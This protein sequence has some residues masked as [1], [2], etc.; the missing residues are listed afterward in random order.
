M[1]ST[2]HEAILSLLESG[3]VPYKVYTHAPC[4]TSEESANARAN[5]GA[6]EAIGAKAILCKM[7]IALTPEFNVL[8]LPGPARLDAVALKML[9]P[10]LKRVRF[11]TAQEMQ[12]LCGL[13][14]GC[15]PPFGPQ[16]FENVTR[17]F[18]DETLREYPMVGF[19]AADFERSIVLRSEDYAR[20][21]SPHAT[22]AKLSIR[23]QLNA[24]GV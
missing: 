23:G 4:R 15:F 2:I 7:Q 5:A 10:G 9:I 14:P 8:V 1:T 19:N 20:I 6:P 17:L 12:D 24:T 11:A 22:F 18:V 3:G 21:V 13:Q 16:V